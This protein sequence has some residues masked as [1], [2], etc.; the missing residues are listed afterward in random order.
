MARWLIEG[1]ET[2]ADI[3]STT[4]FDEPLRAVSGYIRVVQ[5]E[6][7]SQ[8]TSA[9]RS[10]RCQDRLPRLIAFLAPEGKFRFSEPQSRGEIARAMLSPWLDGGAEPVGLVRDQVESFLLRELLDPR[11]RPENWRAAG[12]DA[13][14]LVRRWLARAS[15]K[16]FFELIADHAL[17]MHWKYRDAFW[18]ALLRKDAIDDAWLALGSRVHASARAIRELN[19]AYARLEG[20]GVG[21]DQSILLL[22]VKNTIFCEWSHNG[23]LR[24]WPDNWPD[25]PRLNQ[26]VYA[27]TDVTRK[28]LPFP[29]SHRFGSNGS[30]DGTGLSHIGSERSYWQ[31]SAAE[32]LGKRIGLILD[33]QDWAPE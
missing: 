3:L 28:G 17:D 27:R 22:R 21:S 8:I 20:A 5:T 23:K 11:L 25:A 16:A 4:G 24:A 12:A 1:P 15:L 2:V 31:S 19:G 7:L 18:S 14:N 32:L 6:L 33:P 26:T 29:A 30:P 9:L 13:T 10:N